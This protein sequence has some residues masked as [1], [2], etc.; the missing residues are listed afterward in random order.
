MPLLS[1]FT[2]LTTYKA[3]IDL[4]LICMIKSDR[5]YYTRTDKSA[6]R[7]ILSRRITFPRAYFNIHIKRL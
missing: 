6:G 5:M 2:E 1:G 4:S 7:K 3:K